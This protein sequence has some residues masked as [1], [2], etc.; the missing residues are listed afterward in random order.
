MAAT[1]EDLV[2]VFG[3]K[4]MIGMTDI[5]TCWFDVTPS[6]VLAGPIMSGDM[7]VLLMSV[8]RQLGTGSMTE[9]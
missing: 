6:T 3:D 8:S 1:Q 5:C 9:D 4:R 2:W 7:P